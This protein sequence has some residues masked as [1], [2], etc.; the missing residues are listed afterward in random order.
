MKISLTSNISLCYENNKTKGEKD[1]YILN[2]S[3][4]VEA[5]GK[6]SSNLFFMTRALASLTQSENKKK[7]S[8]QFIQLIIICSCTVTIMTLLC[9]DTSNP[10]K[11]IWEIKQN[12]RLSLLVSFAEQSWEVRNKLLVKT[13]TT[14]KIWSLCYTR[15]TRSCEMSSKK[16]IRTQHVITIKWIIYTFPAHSLLLA[17]DIRESWSQRTRRYNK[18]WQQVIRHEKNS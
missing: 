5:Q 15:T 3:N 9:L 10:S 8:R 2:K 4:Y 1:V 11:N 18:S 14:T 12:P 17:M 16:N 13:L 6:K 7:I